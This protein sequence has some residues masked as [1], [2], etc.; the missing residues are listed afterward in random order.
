MTVRDARNWAMEKL[1]SPLSRAT[2]SPAVDISVILAW[3]LNCDRSFLAA[4]PEFCL[5]EKQE[6]FRLAIEQRCTGR[7]VAY[8]TGHKEFYGLDFYVTPDVLIPKPDTELL[9]DRV[10]QVIEPGQCI[11]DVCTGSG[12]IAVTLAVHSQC[13]ITATD[14][15][16]RALTVARHNST[17]LCPE[18]QPVFLEEDLR[19]GLPSP[20][21]SSGHVQWDILVSNPPYVPEA[22]AYSLLEDG[23]GEPILALNGGIDGLALIRPLAQFGKDVLRHNGRIFLETGEYNAVQ[24]ADYLKSIGYTDVCIHKDLAGCY[25]VVEGLN[26]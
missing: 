3:L 9:I 8:I 17:L 1:K 23:R 19:C 14:I 16:P 18:R 2:N 15:S 13:F 21:E 25:R 10:L 26:S 11:L 12:C 7:A 4:H 6:Q 20:P 5:E 22:T 24:V